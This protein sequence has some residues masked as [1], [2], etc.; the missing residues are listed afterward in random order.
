MTKIISTTSRTMLPSYVDELVSS[1]LPALSFK[2]DPI[3]RSNS[4]TT[5]TMMT[6]TMMNGQS[7]LRQVRQ[8]LAEISSKKSAL[9]EAQVGHA[10]IKN[11]EILGEGEVA[12]AERRLNGYQLQSL[13]VAVEN[14]MKDIA[15]LISAYDALVANHGIEGWTEEDM[16]R[17]EARHHVRRGFELLYRNLIEGGIAREASIE[18]LQQFGVHIQV[19]LAEVQ[20][21]IIATEGFIRDGGRPTASSIEDFLDAMSSKYEYCVGE[22]AQR[23]FG[24]N[25]IVNSN[26]MSVMGNK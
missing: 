24:K 18:Y 17:A 7:P 19:A 22:A 16:E 15:T 4:Q 5:L 1:R 21:Y 9:A 2:T 23:M 25:D 8:I 20:G 6:L 3:S 12:D 11:K 26:L 13:E 10:K 14:S